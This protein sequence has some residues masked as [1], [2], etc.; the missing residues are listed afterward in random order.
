ML[1]NKPYD[2]CIAKNLLIESPRQKG[3]IQ[4]QLDIKYVIVN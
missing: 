3:E 4:L 2:A 1:T